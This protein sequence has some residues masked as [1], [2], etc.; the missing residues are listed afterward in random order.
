MTK[1]KMMIT[2]AALALSA[3]AANAAVYY[4]TDVVDYSVGSCSPKSCAGD[5]Y[6]KMNALGA[7]DEKFTS[8]GMGGSITLGFGT[9][10]SGQNKVTGYEITYS[11]GTPDN[12]HLEA[13]DVYSVMGGVA[14]LLGRITNV[15]GTV[16]SVMSYLPFEHI[17]LVDVTRAEFPGT[18]SFDGFDVDAVAIAA[19]PL[20]A[21]GLMLL[22]GLGGFA[23][24]RRRKKAA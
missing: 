10:F 7:P 18:T 20:P 13:V 17:K 23:A 22:G 4:A 9:S 1:M 12:T 21:A 19:V 14:T 3:G 6:D 5:R 24:L 11:A 2:A 15:G 16:K 8:L